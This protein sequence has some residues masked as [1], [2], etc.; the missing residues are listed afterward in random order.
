MC[1]GCR[2][3]QPRDRLIRLVRRPEGD[4]VLDNAQTL[5]GRG[6]YV[7]RDRRCIEQATRKGGFAKALRRAVPEE[8][9]KDVV[10][11]GQEMS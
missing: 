1:V 9:I 11:L 10:A 5:H 7:C 3:L 6:A 4:V 8:L 2:T